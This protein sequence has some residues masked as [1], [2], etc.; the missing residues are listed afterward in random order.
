LDLCFGMELHD[1]C[2]PGWQRRLS[3][4]HGALVPDYQRRER[5]RRSSM[6][7]ILLFLTVQGQADSSGYR[8]DFGSDCSVTEMTTNLFPVAQRDLTFAGEVDRFTKNP[9]CLLRRVEAGRV[10]RLNEV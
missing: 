7:D 4:S 9:R 5:G 10:F 2:F 1:K 8:S 6:M 3:F